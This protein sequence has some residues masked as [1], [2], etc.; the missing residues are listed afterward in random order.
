MLDLHAGNKAQH[1]TERTDTM[2]EHEF[3]KLCRDGSLF[4]KSK[5]S[6]LRGQCDEYDGAED[7]AAIATAERWEGAAR[8]YEAARYSGPSQWGRQVLRRAIECEKVLTVLE[9]P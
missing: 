5:A 7:S 2:K 1:R 4:C 3:F 9:T 8:L 6:Y